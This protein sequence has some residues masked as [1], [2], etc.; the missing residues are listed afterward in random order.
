MSEISYYDDPE[1]QSP[2]GELMLSDYFDHTNNLMQGSLTKAG[3]FFYE[4]KGRC[5]DY[6]KEYIGLRYDNLSPVLCSDDF[7]DV[8]G[9]NYGVEEQ[10]WKKDLSGKDYKLTDN[11]QYRAYL[12]FCSYGSIT[13]MGVEF[14]LNRVLGYQNRGKPSYKVLYTNYVKE[15]FYISSED[16]A[17]EDCL[18]SDENT[19]NMLI[20]SEE[21]T[22]NH[23]GLY[24]Q[25]GLEYSMVKY[26][27]DYFLLF[28]SEI[29]EFVA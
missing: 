24:I 20:P 18:C 25:E 6:L 11:E 22:K 17:F 19:T 21:E 2:S 26:L 29:Y 13:R 3:F 10:E 15:G 23:L 5:Y 8:L 9:R 12:I 4:L 27:R 28:E 16:R 14:M 1:E 7:L